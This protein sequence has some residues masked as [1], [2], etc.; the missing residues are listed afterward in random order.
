MVCEAFV[1]TNSKFLKHFTLALRYG[2]QSHM[3]VVRCQRIQYGEVPENRTYENTLGK[4]GGRDLKYGMLQEERKQGCRITGAKRRVERWSTVKCDRNNRE[5]EHFPSHIFQGKS[6]LWPM[7]IVWVMKSRWVWLLSHV[8]LGN[9]SEF[10]LQHKALRFAI[11]SQSTGLYWTNPCSQL[12][13]NQWLMQ[14]RALAGPV[15]TAL[16]NWKQPLPLWLNVSPFVIQSGS[17][18]ISN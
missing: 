12:C 3:K 17:S 18:N 13:R 14:C 4:G 2:S 10:S 15:P 6:H 9:S 5:W 1:T 7:R 8:L 11:V 16:C